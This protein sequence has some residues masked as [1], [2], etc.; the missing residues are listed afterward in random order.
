MLP[1]EEP[2]LRRTRRRSCWRTAA[3]ATCGRSACWP[4]SCW[5]GTRPLSASRARTPSSTSCTAA[6]T[7]ARCPPRRA[8][9]VA[10][11]LTKARALQGRQCALFHCI[12]NFNCSYQ[13]DQV[14]QQ[15][16]VFRAAR[17]IACLVCIQEALSSELTEQLGHVVSPLC[18]WSA[19]EADALCQAARRRP[20]V[21]ELM[22]HP[23]IVSLAWKATR[24]RLQPAQ[25]AAVA[26]RFGASPSCSL[27][28]G[29]PCLCAACMLNGAESMRR[30]FLHLQEDSQQL[31]KEGP[32]RAS[33]MVTADCRSGPPGEAAVS[34]G[35]PAAATL[36]RMPRLCSC[37]ATSLHAV[38]CTGI[39]LLE[40]MCGM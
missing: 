7:W 2:A 29:T 38:A 20:T 3:R 1:G 6:P 30:Y 22:V 12:F 23:W 31:A 14:W 18:N 10:A 39:L 17:C 28:T 37:S 4:W 26:W 5:P 33:F 35:G 36:V 27:L 24:P 19:H 34:A 25:A 21:S 32:A 11:A 16:P 13:L 40:G 15:V 9:F 8:H